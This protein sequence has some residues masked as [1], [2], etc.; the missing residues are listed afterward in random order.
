MMQPNPMFTYKPGFC[1]FTQ[2][3]AG[4]VYLQPLTQLSSNILESVIFFSFLVFALRTDNK[5]EIGLHWH[6]N[7]MARLIGTWAETNKIP[8]KR[9]FWLYQWLGFNQRHGGKPLPRFLTSPYTKQTKNKNH[10]FIMFASSDRLTG[11]SAGSFCCF[12]SLS[13]FGG[14][15]LNS[16]S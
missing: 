11:S 13:R 14:F 7:Y 8:S 5:R 3:V 15:Y 12:L 1:L 16:F 4:K 10:L 2:K 9:H 6:I